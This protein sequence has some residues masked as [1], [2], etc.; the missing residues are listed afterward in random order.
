M[1]TGLDYLTWKT[2]NSHDETI[3]ERHFFWIG[4]V[5]HGLGADPLWFKPCRYE[6]SSRLMLDFAVVDYLPAPESIFPRIPMA[7]CGP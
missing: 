4:V 5:K 6:Q 7:Y 3:G 2:V 1:T